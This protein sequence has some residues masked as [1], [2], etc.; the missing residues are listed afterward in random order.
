M[1]ALLP[2]YESSVGPI[3]KMMAAA[4]NNGESD[5]KKIADVVVKLSSMKDIPKRLILGR[6]AET[7]VRQA[8][9]ARAEEAAKYRDFTLSTRFL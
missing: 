5:P 3:Y 4:H 1:P 2:E 9:S 7:Y 6:D 8:E